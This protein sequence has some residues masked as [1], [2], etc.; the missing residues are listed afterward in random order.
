M[1]QIRR[2]F[3]IIMEYWTE[4]SAI[5]TKSTQQLRGPEFEPLDPE[6]RTEWRKTKGDSQTTTMSDTEL[7]ETRESRTE[8]MT[9]KVHP[10]QYEIS[11]SKGWLGNS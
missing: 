2:C 9:Q 10:M 3:L 11:R 1:T 6:R 7:I 8:N 5:G 4:I